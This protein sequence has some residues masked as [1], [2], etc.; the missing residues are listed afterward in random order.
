M[1]INEAKAEWLAISEKK[2]EEI[3]NFYNSKCASLEKEK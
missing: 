3:N 1:I 2:I